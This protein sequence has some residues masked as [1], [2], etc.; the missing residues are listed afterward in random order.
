MKKCE[1][2][3][4]EITEK[5][6]YYVYDGKRNYFCPSHKQETEKYISNL[7]ILEMEE[8]ILNETYK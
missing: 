2:C 4:K 6:G 8:E 7:V 5:V 1:L 3:G